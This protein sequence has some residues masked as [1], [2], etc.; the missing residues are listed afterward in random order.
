MGI[1]AGIGGQIGVAPETTMGTAATPTRFYEFNKEQL[2]LKQNTVQGSGIRAGLTELQASRRTATTREPSGNLDLNLPTK[3]AG[4]WLQQ[5]LGSF[6]AAATQVGTTPAYQQIHVPGS[7]QGHTFTL[8]KGVP[9]SDGTVKPFTYVG[10]KVTDWTMACAM[11]GVLTLSLGID[12]WDELSLATSPASPALAASSYL[13]GVSEFS[14]VGAT[15]STGGTA[16]TSSGLTT[17]TSG[18]TLANVSAWQVKKTNPLKTDRFFFGQGGRKAEQIQNAFSAH[19]GQ[20]TAEFAS[21]AALYDV[22]RAQ[23]PLVMRSSFVGPQIGTSGQYFG[24]DI[25]Q[26]AVVFDGDTPNIDGPDVLG[27]TVPYTAYLDALGNPALQVL[28][29]STDTAV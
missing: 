25:I 18:T 24:L 4:F 15:L 27:I 5:M 26:P 3:G 9:Q 21:Q 6:S 12:A 20:L 17:V 28:Y 2:K 13:A 22:F 8:Q 14:F 29:T 16:A 1:G 10:C 19:S 23:T 11:G 7:L